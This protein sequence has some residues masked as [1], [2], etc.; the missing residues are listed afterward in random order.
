MTLAQLEAANPEVWVS[1]MELR[2]CGLKLPI[3]RS[4]NDEWLVGGVIPKTRIK[5]VI[6]YDGQKWHF[7]QGA[8]EV[9]CQP[10]K[11]PW[12]WNWQKLLWISGKSDARK[13]ADLYVEAVGEEGEQDQNAYVKV[14][15]SDSED[16]HV[17]MYDDG[18]D[19]QNRPSRKRKRKMVNSKEIIKSRRL[20]AEEFAMSSP[21]C[22]W[23]C[24]ACCP[25]GRK[26][27]AVKI[28]RSEDAPENLD[29]LDRHKRAYS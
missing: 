1:I 16:E 23:T 29:T 12:L 5:K 21:T 4:H 8:E 11:L 28:T 18:G 10:G 15:L 9:R 27:Q 24:L 20:N 25:R 7:E 2:H 17:D 6:P 3:A 14:D 13:V 22:N 19:D 26:G